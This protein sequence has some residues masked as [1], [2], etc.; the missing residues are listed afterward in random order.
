LTQ[1]KELC[2]NNAFKVAYLELLLVKL[3]EYF[4]KIVVEH[5]N[6]GDG[7]NNSKDTENSSIKTR[8]G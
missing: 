2:E 1:W 3:R 7:R 4:L 8:L 5:G 6:T